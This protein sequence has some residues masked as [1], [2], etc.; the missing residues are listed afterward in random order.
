MK[1]EFQ[2]QIIEQQQGRIRALEDQ[3]RLLQTQ[4][5]FVQQ[6]Q[7]WQQ[8][9]Q[10]MQHVQQRPLHQQLANVHIYDPMPGMVSEQVGRTSVSNF[11][12]RVT[13]A[14]NR[15]APVDMTVPIVIPPVEP[16]PDDSLPLVSAANITSTL[17]PRATSSPPHIPPLS[18]TTQP[19]TSQPS[20]ALVHNSISVAPLAISTIPPVSHTPASSVDVSSAMTMKPEPTREI[21]TTQPPILRTSVISSSV[22][23]S[24]PAPTAVL[25]ESPRVTPAS[26][27]SNEPILLKTSVPVRQDR[28]S[29]RQ[30]KDSQLRRTGPD[31]SLD[32]PRA[33]KVVISDEEDLDTY[34]WQSSVTGSTS[35]YSYKAY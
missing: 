32:I 25:S 30:H 13:I 18:S 23:A 34:G 7:Q 8:Q 5:Q 28:S 11:T 12:E 2:A 16:T 3:V 4:L 27:V 33:K 9:M 26:R 14:N 6:Q 31:D 17:P 10:Q 19:T 20:A 29:I 15:Y 35:L 21:E 1:N 22:Q 24:A